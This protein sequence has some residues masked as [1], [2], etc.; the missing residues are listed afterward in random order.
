MKNIY[1]VYD[2]SAADVDEDVVF[3]CGTESEAD[4]QEIIMDLTMEDAYFRFIQ[5]LQNPHVRRFPNEGSRL[6]TPEDII[7]LF[8][9]EPCYHWYYT[10]HF[11]PM[12]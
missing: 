6:E 3:L 7:R 5:R 11:I 2:I 8:T 10:Y 9:C 12:L 1:A 4:A